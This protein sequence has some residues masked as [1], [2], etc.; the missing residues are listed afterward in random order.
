MVEAGPDRG[1]VT[2]GRMKVALATQDMKTVNAHFNGARHMAIYEIGPDGYSFVE[3]IQFD[4]VSD[5]DGKH[6]DDG[7]D[8]V[9]AK[10][11][12][13]DGIALLFVKA[14]GGPA[15]ARVVQSRIHP[16]KIPN[17][18]PIVD[19]LDR[20]QTMLKGNPPPWLRKIMTRDGAGENR[21]DFLDDED[22]A[23][24]SL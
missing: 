9:R 1:S 11:K 5:E 6:S 18:E 23:E 8:R 4:A 21:L 10:V 19:V 14:I 12:A 15:A 2:G 13:L 16:M 3:V 20:V 17:D 22:M 7:E 24:E